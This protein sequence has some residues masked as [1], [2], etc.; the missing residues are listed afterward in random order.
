MDTNAK[1]AGETT[2]RLLK[3]EEVAEILGVP[4][5]TLYGWRY[6]QKGPKGLRVG[7]HL[8]YRAEDVERFISNSADR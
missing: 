6:R 4:V 1:S 5:A 8:R 2:N 3:P 7:R